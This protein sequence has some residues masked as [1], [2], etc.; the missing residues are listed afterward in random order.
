MLTTERETLNDITE[1]IVH[2]VSPEKVILFG[3]YAR[4]NE[5]SGSDLDL[6]IIQEKPFIPDGNRRKEM[7]MLWRMLADIKIPKDILIYTP[8]EVAMWKSSLN[9]IVAI[10]LRE[11]IVLYER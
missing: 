4:G 3:S 5:H 6:L 7:G 2:A 8:Q 1:K 11:G 10:A 9:H